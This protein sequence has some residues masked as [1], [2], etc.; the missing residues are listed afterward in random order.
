MR[1]HVRR[2]VALFTAHLWCAEGRA[3]LRIL[4]H[5]TQVIKPRRG[6]WLSPCDNVT[7][8]GCMGGTAAVGAHFRHEAADAEAVIRL[9]GFDKTRLILFHP[10]AWL[11]NEANAV[12]LGADALL[13]DSPEP[14]TLT[15]SFGKVLDW[16]AKSTVPLV[17]T[18]TVVSAETPGT[19]KLDS[20]LSRYVIVTAGR[21]RVGI[22]GLW[23]PHVWVDTLPL[24][25]VKEM[26]DDVVRKQADYVVAICLDKYN[27]WINGTHDDWDKLGVDAVIPPYCADETVCQNVETPQLHG[28]TWVLPSVDR[29]RGGTMGNSIGVFDFDRDSWTNSLRPV[30]GKSVDLLSGDDLPEEWTNTPSYRTDTQWLQRRV[31]EALD[32]DPVLGIS[33][34]VMPDGRIRDGDFEDEVCRRDACPIGE[35]LLTALRHR[36]PEYDMYMFNGGG[37]RYGWDNGT[38]R[39]GHLYGLLPFDNPVCTFN[40]TGPE[41]WKHFERFAA[42]I[43]P[44]G[45][46][47][48]NA[49]DRGGFP[50]TMGI[51]YEFD[52]S[53]PPNKRLLRLDHFNRGSGKWEAVIRGRT[54]SVLTSEFLCSGGDGYDIRM[55]GRV[56]YSWFPQELM[57][58]YIEDTGGIITPPNTASIVFVGDDRPSLALP[59]L[60]AD[61]CGDNQRHLPEWGDCVPCPAGMLQDRLDPTTCYYPPSAEDSVL[62]LWVLI[63]VGALFLLIVP[64]VVWKYTANWRKIR[65]LHSKEVIAVSCAESIAQMRFDEVAYIREIPN[66]DRIQKAFVDIID[67]LIKYRAFM[68]QVLLVEAGDDGDVL[69]EDESETGSVVAGHKG[70]TIRN[71]SVASASD[72]GAESVGSH[73]HRRS[74]QATPEWG[75]Q[76]RGR[77]RTSRIRASRPRFSIDSVARQ[78]EAAKSEALEALSNSSGGQHHPRPKTMTGAR[79]AVVQSDTLIPKRICVVWFGVTGYHHNLQALGPSGDGP[80]YSAEIVGAV[81]YEV[82][83]RGV[84]DHMSGDRMVAHFGAHR[85]C[86]DQ[87]L[88]AAVCALNLSTRVSVICRT[89]SHVG[90]DCGLALVGTIGTLLMRKYS[91][92]GCVMNVAYACSR[93]SREYKCGAVAGERVF[94]ETF[95]HVQYCALLSIAGEKFCGRGN[96]RGMVLYEIICVKERQEVEEWMYQLSK[97]E[98]EDPHAAYNSDMR[99]ASKFRD[100]GQ[101]EGVTATQ[102]EL[103]KDS[104]TDTSDPEARRQRVLQ[105]I[106]ASGPI[107][108]V[109]VE[110]S[111]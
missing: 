49:P 109:P 62:W 103:P 31:N 77:R 69:S 11:L 78:S 34:A 28:R 68:P 36:F 47:D 75:F 14:L 70:A 108:T 60:P 58:E 53:R 99:K 29:G 105:L 15:S 6:S 45:G 39:M 4:L 98:N 72:F 73:S 32:N 37:L 30:G 56:D 100:A 21:Y 13:I 85:V 46:Y 79:S 23:G 16:M 102:S 55:L 1:G 104:E 51:R 33:V 25:M 86:S 42:N 101:T 87:R 35:F 40:T 106:Q 5:Q 38:V 48:D 94:D 43:L 63:G 3:A 81:L 2:V 18:N 67:A 41:L 66:P 89:G 9:V 82:S 7:R 71:E 84:L 64:P 74:L 76:R 10:D 91:A 19:F 111:F 27:F 92:I 24:S 52:P 95:T 17:V 57:M 12:R 8:E 93:L 107:R 97:A 65:R 90:V 83:F 50:Q 61:A 44:D 110:T 88:T 20:Y 80:A 26:V 54:Y 59:W 22:L 96:G